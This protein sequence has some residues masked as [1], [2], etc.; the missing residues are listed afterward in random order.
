MM[1][2]KP[3]DVMKIKRRYVNCCSKVSGLVRE[4][5]RKCLAFVK[6]DVDSSYARCRECAKDNYTL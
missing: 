2:K 6:A 1:S 3:V 4:E 5:R